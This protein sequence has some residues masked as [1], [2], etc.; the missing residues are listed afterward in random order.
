MGYAVAFTDLVSDYIAAF[1]ELTDDDRAAVVSGVRD[2]LSRD[3]DVFLASR[4][5]AHESLHFR[6]DYPHPTRHTL[7]TF[8]FIVDASHRAVGVVRVVY[9]ECATEPM[10]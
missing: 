4:P 6:Y 9:V 10:A 2:E 3:A 7:F 8:D 5:L 1:P